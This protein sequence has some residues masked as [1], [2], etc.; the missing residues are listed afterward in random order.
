MS[1]KDMEVVGMTRRFA[2]RVSRAVNEAEGRPRNSPAHLTS[3]VPN[4]AWKVRALSV[5]TIPAGT[6]ATPSA[7]QAQIYGLDLATGSWE[8]SGDPVDV[9]NQY[10]P[11]PILDNTA[12]TL[13]WISGWWFVDSAGCTPEPTP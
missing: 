11:D 5:G 1:S 3:G 9:Y 2:G 4:V 8:E 6:F 12:M 7:G 10:G 13:A